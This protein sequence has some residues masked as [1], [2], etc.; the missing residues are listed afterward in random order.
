MNTNT[1]K[2]QS[3]IIEK[4]DE[5]H[6][7]LYFIGSGIGYLHS[8]G[9]V[10]GSTVNEDGDYTGY[11]TTKL[12]AQLVYDIFDK[13]QRFEKFLQPIDENEKEK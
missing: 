5:F 2:P 10:R 6:M 3:P 13:N 9:I 7:K 4:T 8:D 1:P 11:Y 12:H